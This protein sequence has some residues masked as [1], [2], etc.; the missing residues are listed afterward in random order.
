MK[1]FIVSALYDYEHY[2]RIYGV[3]LSRQKAEEMRKEITEGTISWI[4]EYTLDRKKDY[5]W[6]DD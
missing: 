2:E 1:I 6:F 4:T 5:V 3:A